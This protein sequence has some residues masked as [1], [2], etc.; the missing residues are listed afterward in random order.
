MIQQGSVAGLCELD[1]ERVLRSYSGVNEDSSLF[2]CDTALLSKWLVTYPRS[3][4]P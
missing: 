1:D 4:L 2:G 3:L